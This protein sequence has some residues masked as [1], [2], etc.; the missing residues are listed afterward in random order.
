MRTLSIFNSTVIGLDIVYFTSLGGLISLVSLDTSFFGLEFLF[1]I[2][3]L[4][5]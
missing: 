5:M 3:F 2:I 1:A 4:P